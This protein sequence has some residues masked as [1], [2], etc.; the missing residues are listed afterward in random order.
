M[1]SWG[2]QEEGSSCLADNVHLRLVR[3][4][5]ASILELPHV[6]GSL[7]GTFS[8]RFSKIPEAYN[9]TGRVVIQLA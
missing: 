3:F 4:Q 9:V 7:Q 5:R 2:R 8:E 1:C 6:V